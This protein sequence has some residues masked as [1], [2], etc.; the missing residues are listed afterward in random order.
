MT[1]ESESRANEGTLRLYLCG[2]VMTGR[3]IDQIL[4]HP[5]DPQLHEPWVTDARY[6][7]ELAERAHGQVPRPTAIDYIWGDALEEWERM[8]PVVGIANL[9]TAITTSNDWW[10][11]K[12]I[13]YRMSPQNIGCL[14]AAR[15][16][17]Y[18]LAN[19]HVL[20]WGYEGLRETLDT[21]RKAGFQTAGAGCDRREA[22]APAVM[23]IGSTCRVL[24][25][26][27]GSPTAGIPPAWRATENRAGVNLLRDFSAATVRQIGLAMEEYRRE[28][29]LLVVSV[30]WGGNWGYEVSTEQRR[31]ARQLI[32]LVGVDIVHGHSSH[33]VKAIEIYQNRLILYGCGDF[34][35][36]Y[37][38][39][40]GYEQ[41]RG[42]LA[43]MYFATVEA[44]TGSLVSLEM[45]PLQMRRM[46]LRRVEPEDRD[47]LRQ[48]LNQQCAPFGT[49]IGLC[50]D[51]LMLLPA[52]P[53]LP[54]DA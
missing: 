6:Y 8:A 43:L 11:E 17:C 38:G 44:A 3:G 23:T 7:W 50:D 33:H 48:H 26:A 45:T 29:D 24:V 15:I 2:D 54:P 40:S 36:D 14:R 31:F 18:A 1:A 46:Q 39:I 13:H 49:R 42:D 9:E 25:Y 30:H 4:P 28:G 47:W 20:D 37:E 35:T 51:R 53:K 16:D 5:S 21:L 52:L 34:L 12:E 32:D 41:F 19:N 10:P 27:C 22:E